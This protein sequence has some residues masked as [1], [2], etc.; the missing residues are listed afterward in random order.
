MTEKGAFLLGVANPKAYLAFASLL[1]SF[2]LLPQQHAVADGALKWALCVVVMVV[3]DF[4]WLTLGMMFEK[5]TLSLRAE[6]LLNIV[7]G[8]TI[9]GS[10]ATMWL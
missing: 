2:T 6:R 9:A 4:G 5:L 10:C 8:A 3:V 7:M 1:G